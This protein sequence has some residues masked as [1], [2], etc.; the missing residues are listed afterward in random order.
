MS[1]GWWWVCAI[2]LQQKSPDCPP[3]IARSAIASLLCTGNL[4]PRISAGEF[5]HQQAKGIL[6][7]GRSHCGATCILHCFNKGRLS[8]PKRMNF[9]RLPKVISDP[10]YFVADLFGNFEVK[11]Q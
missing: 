1:G 4:V 3:P 9:R 10:K 6:G 2:L 8:P 5:S 11:K 7:P